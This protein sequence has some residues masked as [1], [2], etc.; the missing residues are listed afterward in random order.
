MSRLRSVRFVL[1]LF[2]TY[3][4]LPSFPAQAN[5][6]RAANDGTGTTVRRQGD[7]FTIT[8]G[9]RSRDGANL[10]HSLEQLG[11]SREQIANFQSSPDVRNILTRITGGDASIIDGLIQVSGSNA[12]LYLMNPAGIV[13]GRNARLDVPGS[14]TATTA[15]GIGLDENWFSAIDQNNYAALV[16]NPGNYA[17]ALS[18]AGS[19]VNAGN[20]SVSSGQRLTLLGGTVLNVGQLSAP[21]GEVLLTAVPGQS[22]VRLNQIGSLLSLEITAEPEQTQLSPLSPLSLPQLLTGGAVQ[23]ATGLSISP[24]GRIRLGGSDVQLSD[25]G[26]S[27][28]ASGSIDVSSTNSNGGTVL[29]T[30]DRTALIEATIRANGATGGGTILI[31]GEYQGGGGIA[32]AERTL[33][34]PNTQLQA[35]ATA[36]GNGGRVI[37]W[38]DDTTEFWGRITARGTSLT[39]NAEMTSPVLSNGGFVEVSGK[40]TLVFRGTVDLSAPNGQTGTLLLDPR[41]IRITSGTPSIIPP[42]SFDIAADTNGTTTDTTIVLEDL[43]SAIGQ[44]RLQASRDIIIDSK[45][46]LP[47]FNR[48]PQRNSGDNIDFLAGRDFSSNASLDTNGRSL[49]IQAGRNISIQNITTL[50]LNRIGN[51]TLQAG[52]NIT[53]GNLS[54]LQGS[55]SRP[56]NLSSA[57]ALTAPNGTIQVNS[58]D[59][60][61]NLGTFQQQGTGTITVQADTFRV[62]GTIPNLADTSIAARAV[63]IDHAGGA[64]NVPFVV[65]DSRVN[66]TAA[67]IQVQNGRLPEAQGVPTVEFPVL[68]NGGDSNTNLLGLTVRSRNTPPV[69][70]LNGNEVNPSREI[71]IDGQLGQAITL[72]VPANA[73]LSSQDVNRD[74]TIFVI[75]SIAKGGRVTR[76]GVE[77]QVNDRLFAGDVL[78]YENSEDTV[79]IQFALEVVAVDLNNGSPRLSTSGALQFQARLRAAPATPPPTEPIPTNP[80][81]IQPTEMEPTDVDIVD[82]D[83]A[84]IANLEELETISELEALDVD[85]DQEAVLEN[86][87]TEAFSSY[88]G[89]DNTQVKTVEQT[90]D[91]IRGIARR[92]GI[93]SALLYLDFAPE[94]VSL[95]GDTNYAY[96]SDRLEL[97]LVTANGQRRKRINVTRGEFIN[98]VTEFRR[99]ITDVRQLD[100]QL[101]LPSAQKLYQWI[102]APL[103]AE[104]SQ[105]EIGNL[106]FIPENGLRSLPYAALH[107]GKQFLIEKYSLNIMPSMSLTNTDYQDIRNSEVLAVGVSE[108]VSGQLPLPTVP[109][110]LSAVM[111]FWEGGRSLLNQDATLENL[112]SSRQ[113]MPYGIIHLA[114]HANFIAEDNS[115]SYIQLWDDRLR[116]D[117]L[118]QLGWND[119]PVEL[120]VLSACRTALGDE[121]TELG[122]AGLAVQAG[123]KTVV[124]SLWYVNDTATT[125]LMSKFYEQLNQSPIKAEA[126]RQT[127]IA[128]IQGRIRIE[129]G[130]VR[131]L[132][133]L[134][135]VALPGADQGSDRTLS[136]PYYWAAFTMVGN[137]W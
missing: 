37:L 80:I 47:P 110:E 13:F 134:E 59:G 41:D 68:A 25:E 100:S 55:E 40:E 70:S 15:T 61:G 36:S 115:K 93:Q 16:G 18:Q 66:G 29:V 101:Y 128:M 95:G 51:I 87:N 33:V 53:A 121:T 49:S 3:C 119:P 122:F 64:N 12:H 21:G 28:I 135:S 137:P 45:D 78:Q 111:N 19:I 127:Q 44:I 57:I 65:G 104:L 39:P 86:D 118:R 20:L 69:I 73:N 1:I 74:N 91:T 76:N 84:A 112:R 23:A 108:G 114:T 132:D 38:A 5:P 103:E 98:T 77:L 116:L 34:S 4:F 125:A 133:Q 89:L 32:T 129:N 22:R 17:F 7:R 14:F 31:G 90:Q 67:A 94:G 72:Q 54:T 62:L 120:L 9:Q 42:S 8:G 27:A 11:L 124:A 88:F 81:P 75:N 46:T 126:L 117:Q 97:T 43:V 26:G 107:D 96:D 24:T 71:V 92:T 58:I 99:T 82:Q 63:T 56:S 83:F 109:T 102:V 130:Q 60:R 52:G 85:L 113:R 30:G 123:V 48:D 136:D 131:G 6:V 106:V 10:F 105:E 2:A 35:D 79:G 50:G